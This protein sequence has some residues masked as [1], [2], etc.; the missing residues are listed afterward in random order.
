MGVAMA[1]CG[2]GFG[3]NL[4][5]CIKNGARHAN[6][7]IYPILQYILMFFVTITLFVLLLSILVFSAYTVDEKYFKTKFGFITSRYEVQKIAVITLD[8]KTNK[9]TVT[10]TDDQYIIVVVKKEWYEEFVTALLTANP[11]I[12]YE[13]ISLES[14][15]TDKDKN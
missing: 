1:L 13:I 6:D 4:F 15:G 12:R 10:F 5:Y 7:P 9:L 14:D 2:V 8:R 11:V 3:V